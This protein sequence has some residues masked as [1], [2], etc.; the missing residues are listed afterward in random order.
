[1][2]LR[3]YNLPLRMHILKATFLVL[4]AGLL[5]GCAEDSANRPAPTII[6]V[7]P[8]RALATAKPVPPAATAMPPTPTTVML[9]PATSTPAQTVSGLARLTILYTND[10]RGYVD[11]CG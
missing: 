2:S 9:S 8:S 5:I 1:M 4:L 7:A 3:R 6:P 10:T 11:P